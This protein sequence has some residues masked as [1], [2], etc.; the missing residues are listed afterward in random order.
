MSKVS[1][2]GNNNEVKLIEKMYYSYFNDYEDDGFLYEECFFYQFYVINCFF[3]FKLV[4]KFNN[5]QELL[6]KIKEKMLKVYY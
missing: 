2:W 1:Y 4:D 6:N 5:F 3:Y